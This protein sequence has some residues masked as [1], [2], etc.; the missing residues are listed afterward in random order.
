MKYLTATILVAGIVLGSDQIPGPDQTRP[1]LLKNG[2]IHTVS[3]ETHAGWDLLFENGKISRIA[4]VIAESSDMDIRDISGKHVYP[5]LISSGTMMGLIEIQAVRATNDLNESGSLNPNVK[6]NVSYNPDSELIP[7]ARANGI[8]VANVIPAA[9][10]ISGQSSVMMLDGWTWEDATLEAPTAL[11][12]NWPSMKIGTGDKQKMEEARKERAE[13]TAE[14]DRFFNQV[15]AYATLIGSKKKEV[16]LNTGH[17]LKLASM[18][19]YVKGI[20]PIFIH[21]DEVRQIEAAVHWGEKQGVSIVIVGGLDAWRVPDLLKEHGIPVIFENVLTLPLRRYEHY[22]QPYRTPL[23]LH[24]AG[25][26]FSIVTPINTM[27]APHLRNLPYEAAMAAAYGLPEEK[28]L[29]AITLSAAEI[30]GVDNR[31]GSLEP[32]KDATLFVADGDIL[33]IRS[34]VEN[35]WIQ[36]RAVDLDNRHKQLYRKYQEKYQQLGRID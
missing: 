8:L 18:I 12:I 1:V 28:A 30:L 15:R 6:T 25:V 22:D 5:G 10:L 19:P 13:K 14:L 16:D 2:T 3:G 31:I 26:R 24:E 27:E 35:A 32:G 4:E 9:G 34:H 21:A 29:K 20:K 33:D 17:D 23:I 7:V 11:H 36:G